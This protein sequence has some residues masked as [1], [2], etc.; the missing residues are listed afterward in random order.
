MKL[1]RVV[2][3]IILVAGLSSQG[4]CNAVDGASN[5]LFLGFSN[6]VN[7]FIFSV[8]A[9]TAVGVAEGLGLIEET[10]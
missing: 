4:G 2:L 9:L 3:T 8:Y 10:E 6:V 7:S 1:R 5:G